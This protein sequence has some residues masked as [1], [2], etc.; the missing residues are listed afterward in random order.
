MLV[1]APELG[2]RAGRAACVFALLLLV[3]AGGGC[4]KSAP[5]PLVLPPVPPETVARVH[6]LGKQRLAADTN[7]AFVM[8]IWNLAESKALEAQTLDRMAVGLTASHQSSVISNQLAV[9]SNQLSVTGLQSTIT[10][11]PPQ[12]TGPAAL[13][14]PLLDDLVQQ[15][16][17]VEVRQAT[18]Q[19]GELACAI[20]LSAE[21][22][23]LWQTNLAAFVES[24]TGSRVV[25]GPGRTSGWQLQITSH[26]SQTARFIDLAR[27]GDWTVIGLGRETNALHAEMLA[28]IERDGRPFASQPKQYWLYADLDLRRVASALSSGWELPADLPRITVAIDGDAQNVHTR[29]KFKFLLP[30]PAD[31]EKWN[32]PTNLMHDPLCSFTAIRGIGPRLSAMNIWNDLQAG[33][34]PNQLYFWAQAGIPFLSFCAAPLP[35]ASNL[36]YQLKG[37]LLQQ[38]NA[39][40]ATN[41]LGQFAGATHGNGVLWSN[42]P[43]MDPFLRSVST[44]GGDFA[45]VGMNPA[46]STNR[47]AP[48]ALFQQVLISTNLVAYDW[49]LTGPRI[50]QWLFTGQFL[51]MVTHLAQV[52]SKSASVVWL[53]ALGP[54][55]GNS[56]T[57]VTRTS[58]NELSFTRSSS[59]GFTAVELHLLVDWLESPQFPRGLN[60]LLGE[61][62]PLPRKKAPRPGSGSRTNSVP[63]VGP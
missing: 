17:Y 40:L 16:S 24:L 54:K 3:T 25:A 43:I 38:G 60:T 42:L 51:R 39:Y 2:T 35:N 11:Q 62:T 18:N 33:A 14:R 52:P 30:L 20:R 5:A 48:A 15:E 47:P 46:V 29:G 8:G 22:A 56:A 21:R 6:W 44:T 28:L 27:V 34:P 26:Q 50:E 37:R 4:K 7:A 10:N 12:L 9:V 63:P 55:L 53:S 23:R 36:V 13:L 19:P 61:P 32:I 58:P 57:T 49:E 41:G 45:V 31:L 59:L 1:G